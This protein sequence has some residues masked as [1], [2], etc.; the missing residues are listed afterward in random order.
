MV[1][2]DREQHPGRPLAGRVALVTGG[3]RGIGA[4]I[5]RALAAQGATVAAAYSGNT[6]AAEAFQRDFAE[7]QPDGTLSVH[8]GD[9]GVGED[10]RRIV[11]EV[12]E[13]HG[14]LDILVNNAGITNDRLL[15][16]MTDEDWRSVMAVN[17]D[18]AFFMA[19]AALGHML[20]RGSGRVIFVGSIVGDIGNI[21][22]S[23]YSASKSALYGLTKSLARETA[24]LL[25]RAGKLDN[26]TGV[27]VNAVSPGV[28]GTEMVQAIPEKIQQGL[29]AEIPIRRFGGPQEVAHVVGFLASDDASYVTGQI[30][31]VNGGKAM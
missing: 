15:L 27:T 20:E 21:G 8:R 2:D 22:Q 10:C 5:S 31:R 26:P 11:A 23:N 13:Q 29:I 18:G 25:E 30:W 14:R 9:V 17:L 16:K 1:D 4:A 19:Q 6:E 24:F 28:I 7:E 3:T 12:I